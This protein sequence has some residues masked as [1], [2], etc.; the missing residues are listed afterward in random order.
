MS[1]DLFLCAC[2][3]HPLGV[4]CVKN[5][6]PHTQVLRLRLSLLHRAPPVRV[7]LG[8][9]SCPRCKLASWSIA[10]GGVEAGPKSFLSTRCFLSLLPILNL[11]PTCLVPGCEDIQKAVGCLAVYFSQVTAGLLDC[12]TFSLCRS[13]VTRVPPSHNWEWNVCPGL[14]KAFYQGMKAKWQHH[15]CLMPCM[16]II[17]EESDCYFVGGAAV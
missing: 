4:H 15:P 8:R 1:G 16:C 13:Q 2:W 14:D 17:V 12:E 9:E 10:W 7:V 3:H 11:R 5:P 6:H